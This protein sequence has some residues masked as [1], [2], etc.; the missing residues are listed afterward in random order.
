V[1]R[2][3]P[4]PRSRIFVAAALGLA[5]YTYSVQQTLVIPSLLP[6]QHDLHTSTAWAA[7]LLSGFLLVSCVTTPLVGKLGDQFGKKRL[8]VLSLAVFLLGS[9]LASI[10]PNI[11]TLIGARLVQGAGGGILPL[12]AAL[13]RDHFP[14]ERVTVVVGFLYSM[15]TLGITS[16]TVVAGLVIDHVSWRVLFGVG[17]GLAA[18]ALLLAA[19]LVP[20]STVRLRTRLD[21]RGA[22]LLS[23]GLL[24]ILLALT[25]GDSW[26]WQSGRTLGLFAA[27]A[28]VLAFWT[29]LELRVDEPMVD[30]RMLTHRPVL[31]T[32][33]SSLVWG[34]AI[35][36][37]LALVPRFSELPRGLPPELASRVH[38]GLGVSATTAALYLVPGLLVG[39]ASGPA[40][41]LF[42]RRFGAKWALVAG[43]VLVTAGSAS[44]AIWH[45]RPWQIVAGM[46]LI[47]VGWPLGSAAMPMIVLAVVRPTETGIATGMTHVARVI[48]GSVATQLGAAILTTYE[49]RGTR[50]PTEGAFVAM[51]WVCA[52][53]AASA[54]V[55]GFLVTPRRQRAPL[56]VAE[57]VT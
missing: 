3:G 17:A 47:G 30:I 7:W 19:T 43:A 56:A 42:G 50:I 6:L 8:L 28:A 23:L 24:A 46:F 25:E 38:Y 15:I 18:A 13:V 37:A 32:N 33:A 54:I 16:G 26:G 52:A 22:L 49:I 51:F 40:G 27:S 11:G 10:A 5:V 36:G 4:K 14:T 53:A 21:V 34:V 35:F 31:L 39:L 2:A 12:S 9:I 1:P 55:M 41:A 20:E 29:W 45:D 48:G 57:A 44:L